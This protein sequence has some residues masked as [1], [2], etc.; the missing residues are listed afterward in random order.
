MIIV[1]LHLMV[2]LQ[3]V[4]LICLDLVK[5][6]MEKGMSQSMKRHGILNIQLIMMIREQD[7]NLCG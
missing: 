7:F 4:L 2:S 6:I 1:R 5:R 3:V